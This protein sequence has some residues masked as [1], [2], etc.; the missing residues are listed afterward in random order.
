MTASHLCAGLLGLDHGIKPFFWQKGNPGSNSLT[1]GPVPAR[2][3]A[4]AEV[5]RNPTRGDSPDPAAGAPE[6]SSPIRPPAL[7]ATQ[8][9]KLRVS[10]MRRAKRRISYLLENR[11]AGQGWAEGGHV[12]PC[13]NC[14][15]KHTGAWCGPGGRKRRLRMTSV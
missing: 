4:Q 15:L 6:S 7:P 10:D 1:K 2:L 8:V 13:S 5:G 11:G 3:A 12:F 9:W 14:D